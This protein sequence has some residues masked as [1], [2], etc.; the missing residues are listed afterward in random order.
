MVS[1]MRPA[2]VAG[3]Q[4]LAAREI[5]EK[6]ARLRSA[7]WARSFSCSSR[8]VVPTLA[9]RTQVSPPSAR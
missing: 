3:A 8:S 2:A 6:P 5:G 4:G 7:A 1:A 9:P